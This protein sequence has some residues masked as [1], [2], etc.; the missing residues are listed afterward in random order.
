MEN[1]GRS[2]V[3]LIA[4]RFGAGSS[5]VLYSG[6]GRNGGDG[7][8]AARHLAGR[9]FKVA[10]RLVGSS[11]TI[12]D[13]L[14][15]ANW[16]ALK[17]MTESTQVQ[18]CADSTLLT[19][20]ESD[21]VVDAILGTGAK[22]KLRQ[23]ITHAVEAINESGGFKVAVDV[24]TGIDSDSG[25]V[26]GDA[27]R[28]NVTVTFHAAKPGLKNAAE[29]CGEIVVA[30]IG[31]PPEAS[32]YA[33]PGDVEAVRVR[34]PAT[35][36][37]GQYGRLLVIGGSETF[38][39]APTL[40][41][42]AAYRTGTDLVFVAAPEKTANIVSS[43][44]PNLISIKLPG[45]NLTLNHRSLLRDQIKRA[46]AIAIGPG[47]G[48][49]T[50]TL[51]AVRHILADIQQLKKPLLVDA[52]AF[53]AVGL[54]KKRVFQGSTVL[55]PHAGEFKLIAGK[56]PSAE[57]R[58]RSDEVKATAEK[59]GGVILLKGNTD[60]ISNGE[61]VKLNRTGNPGMTV[62][63]TGDVL[64]GVISGLL[65]QGVDP[66]RAAVAGAFINGAA[67]DLSEEELGDHLTPTDLLG[68]I[69]EVMNDPMCHR[70]I[71]EKR[72]R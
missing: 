19:R 58:T 18:E 42:L 30:D 50:K 22:G 1:A 21:V 29:F 71:Y 51:S 72:L 38:T 68:H 20:T 47:L 31:I 6:T 23:P 37:K 17:S 57:L 48:E 45:E 12:T 28:A 63:G 27:V 61:L 3:D 59:S 54:I 11:K 25:E 15:H 5:V 44:S 13:P 36:H 43:M 32:L 26:L 35:A 41:A 24:P 8:V 56:A 52:D 4:A 53:K 39:G 33:G 7:M 10:L 46:T 70:A 65:A 66:Y 60:V 16:F 9:G 14:V 55:T 49:N 40:V 67:G 69:P 2:V 62:G 34:R 64:S